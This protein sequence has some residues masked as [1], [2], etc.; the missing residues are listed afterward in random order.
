MLEAVS[1]GLPCVASRVGACASI[2]GGGELGVLIGRVCPEELANGILQ[3]LEKGGI[4]IEKREKFL[5]QWDWK[6]RVE[7]FIQ[8]VKKRMKWNN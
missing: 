2:L 1:V 7:R 4:G 8:S 6:V 5:A 3:S